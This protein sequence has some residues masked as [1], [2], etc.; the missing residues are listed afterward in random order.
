[1]SYNANMKPMT[2]TDIA[3]V[4]NTLHLHN[5][6]AIAVFDMDMR[7]LFASDKWF[8][9]SG[10]EKTNIIGLCHYDIFPELREMPDWMDVHQRVLNGETIEQPHDHFRREHGR[11][12][13]S[14][15]KMAPWFK[16]DSNE[17][18]GAVLYAQDVTINRQIHINKEDVPEDYQ[19]QT[20][21]DLSKGL[22]ELSNAITDITELQ[23]REKQNIYHATVLSTQHIL[24]NFLNQLSIVDIEIKKNPTFDEN[25][26][27][28]FK[29]MKQQAK[30]LV[31][32]L[33]S[34]EDINA[35][36]IKQSVH[37]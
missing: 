36:S 16:R 11:V 19:Q 26:K 10:I 37:P 35:D 17:Q 8:E 9:H 14:R 4:L 30:E 15:W 33:S 5:P 18:G 22:L 25:V 27:H 23:H 3:D 29:A 32:K 28:K 2:N 24:N 21:C 13:Y 6:L 12:Q 1:M 31:E 34:I 7:Y 20:N